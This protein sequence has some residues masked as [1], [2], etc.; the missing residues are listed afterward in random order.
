MR[1]ARGYVELAE[2]VN[3]PIPRPVDFS[4]PWGDALRVLDD[5]APDV[6]VINLE[7]SITRSDDVA[8][9]KAVHYRMTPENTP[10]LT[11]GRPDVCALT[12][13]HVLDFGYDG[14]A[15]TLDALAAAGIRTVGAGRPLPA[16]AAQRARATRRLM[17]LRP[18][19]C[20]TAGRGYFNRL[21]MPRAAAQ[22]RRRR[23][24]V[25]L[26]L[27]VIAVALAPDPAPA[28]LASTSPPDGAMLTPAPTEI[29][30][31]FTDPV[32]PGLSHVSVRDG[33]GASVNAG[34]HRLAAAQRLRQPVDIVTT[35]DS[36]TVAYHITFIDDTSLTGTLRFSV[37]TAT[38]VY[39]VATAGPTP[40]PTTRRPR[41]RTGMASTR[42]AP[43]SWPSTASLRLRWSRS[44]CAGQGSAPTS[45][46]STAVV[47]AVGNVTP[48][49]SASAPKA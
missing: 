35:A 23:R 45:A 44:S 21:T 43:P 13:N 24:G 12:N 10:G 36:L 41:P 2:A 3:G 30:L 15:D 42:S 6:R 26:V 29:E 48:V 31:T 17:Q 22:S 1:D 27:M 25:A 11:A 28:A 49:P 5:V 8:H 39:A 19:P 7:T 46:A 33:S 34:H 47:S 38:A 40:P 9:G 32:N 37:R 20:G 4:W 14:L 16:F 18:P